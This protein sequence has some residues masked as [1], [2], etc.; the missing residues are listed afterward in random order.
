[1]QTLVRGRT[2][3]GRAGGCGTVGEDTW[4]GGK[5]S[6]AE[7][8]E[9][10]R[11]HALRDGERGD[12]R[13]TTDRRNRLCITSTIFVDSAPATASSHASTKMHHRLHP[14]SSHNTS[15]N[16]HHRPRQSLPSPP[17]Q[18]TPPPASTPSPA[19]PRSAAPENHPHCAISPDRWRT[20]VS[21]V[22]G[23]IVRKILDWKPWWP[24]VPWHELVVRFVR[25]H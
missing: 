25:L 18:N 14:L 4:C 9:G 16:P 19:P 13:L 12:I 7:R 6:E 5:T 23:R 20:R 15:L 11:R 8:C 22:G 2:Q 10:L 3:G 24:G 21:P 17:P 1:M